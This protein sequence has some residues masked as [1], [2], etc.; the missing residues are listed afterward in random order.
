MVALGGI[1]PRALLAVLLLHANE[2]VSAERLALALWGEDA[3]GGAA[4]TVQVHVSRL[5]KALGEADVIATTPAGYCLGVRRDELDAARFEHLVDDGRRALRDGRPQYAAMLLREA[6]ALW[7]GPALAE[8]AFEPF[9]Q[10]EVARLH[11]HRLAA[12]EARIEADLAA[13]DHADIV[14][15]LQQLVGEH[16]LR[17]GLAAHLMLALYRCGRQVEALAVYRDLR[18]VLVATIG[19]EPGRRLRQ[20]HEAILRQDPALELSPGVPDLSPEL[21]TTGAPPIAGRDGE[22]SWLRARWDRARDGA[23]GLVAITGPAGAGKSR[24]AAEL[25]GKVHRR[26]D[27]VLHATGSGPPAAV[28]AALRAARAA[29]R[30]A[31]LVVDDAGIASADVLEQ[32]AAA[33]ASLAREPVLVVL[34]CEDADALGAVSIDGV[35]ALGGLGEGEVRTIARRYASG[36]AAQEIP[37]GWMLEASGGV[38]GRIH[39]VASQWA[40]REAARRVTAVAGRAAVERGQLREVQDELAGEVVELQAARERIRQ[41]HAGDDPLVVCPFKGLAAYEMADAAYFFGRE[42]LVAE[43]VAR[44]VGT[45]LLAVVGPSGSGKSSVVRAGLLP[46]L[47]SGV[48]PGSDGWTQAL[49]RP[50]ARPAHELRGALA[51]LATDR[52][53]VVVI[54]QFEE[55]FTVCADE[56]ERARF[57]SMLVEIA[58]G[59][60]G[61]HVVV[62]AVRADQYGRCADFPGLSALV[63]ANTVLVSSLQRNELRRA[64]QGPCDRAGLRADAELVD[65][66]VSDVEHEPGGL[67]LLSAALLELW[68]HRDGR[69]LRIEHY[70]R[71]GGV[72]GA[73]ARLADDAYA[74][75]DGDRQVVARAVLMRLVGATDGDGVE[76]RRVA[77]DELDVDRHEDVARVVALLT[78]RRLL[79]V[80]AG[81]VELAHEALLREWPRLRD[82]I[83]D[84]RDGLRIQRRVSDAA[85]EWQRLAHDDGAL[86]RGSR[87]AEASQWTASRPVAANELERTFLAAGQAAERRDAEATRRRTRRLRILAASLAALVVIVGALGIS[88]LRQRSVAR[89]EAAQATSLALASAA[90]A[91]VKTRPDVAALLAFE[92]YS[93][94]PRVEARNSMLAG[95]IA[96]RRP[97]ILAILHGHSDAVSAVAFSPNGRTI[98][99]GSWDATVRFWDAR[100]HRRLGPP[101][102]GHRGFVNGVAFSPDGSMLASASSDMTIRLWSVRTHRQLGAALTGDTAAV[103]S[104]A[105]SP[106]GHTLVSGS[107]DK[108]VRL[109]DV[110]THRQLGAPL[111]GDTQTVQTVAFSPDDRTVASGSWDHTV[112]LWSARTHRQLGAPLT[113]HTDGV[114]GLAFGPRGATLASGG[115]DNTIRLWDVRTRRQLGRPLR[116]SLIQGLAFSPDGRMLASGGQTPRLWDL[117][118][119]RLLTPLFTQPALVFN[120]AFSPD[121]HTLASA[122]GDGTIDLWDV[123]RRAGLARTLTGQTSQVAGISYARDGRTLLSA[124]ADGAV[125]TWQTAT[126][127]AL[128]APLARHPTAV[129]SPVFSHDGRTLASRDPDGKTR[130]RD[131]ATGRLLGVLP[132]ANVALGKSV[133]FSPDDRTLAAIEGDAVRLWDVRSRAQLGAPLRVGGLPGSVAFSPDGHTLAVAQSAIQLWDVRT[134]RRLGRPLI[135]HS[136]GVSAMVFSADGQMLVSADIAGSIRFWDVGTRKA[137][138]IPV[139]FSDKHTPTLSALALTPD[140]R[141]LASGAI[142]GTIDLWDVPARVQIGPSLIAPTAIRPGALDPDAVRG[143]QFSPDG[144]TL[145]SAAGATIRL[146][147]GLLWHGAGELGS[148]VCRLM[149]GGLD[150][151]EWGLYAGGAAYRSSCP[152]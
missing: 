42:R 48:L 85:R 105:F 133:A 14:A 83:D 119:H 38:A 77:L 93:A 37:A 44:L 46:A 58:E 54:D 139:A 24:L 95:L 70:E 49:L 2:P 11:E 62:L 138:G 123:R 21:D 4:K 84:D 124:G 19:I 116:A 64:V 72:H 7:R 16:P 125:E 45:T 23:G 71:T 18:G 27:V 144:R 41:Q 90:Q 140:G 52:R 149:G 35:L 36:G 32:L 3:P 134:H 47:A 131:T 13:N 22:L 82:W 126:G 143:L 28:I 75:L 25:A 118:T 29:S 86:L 39:E 73:V 120:V 102:R 30:P 89:R 87:L 98:A 129:V 110:R 50:G 136:D 88:A 76:R 78:D 67:P 59:V 91:Q 146:W 107:D 63:T 20:R 103:E 132:G 68:Q 80:S 128:R 104:V 8:L 92:A 1:K 137:L 6:L 99:S 114:Y 12:L 96:A 81:S 57:V 17:E 141:T 112:R 142:D 100:T 130:L 74:L 51:D 122:D 111:T 101:L 94:S 33:M 121:G 65:A 109:W 106:D 66:L 117:R 152:S 60:R 56:R 26:G 55:A 31:L 79:S 145:A 40:R 148:E 61:P 135:G 115:Y 97:G 9:A 10:T 34:C 151:R 69:R 43:L 5:R 113:A 147:T 53:G 108:T 127:R 150:R 15:E